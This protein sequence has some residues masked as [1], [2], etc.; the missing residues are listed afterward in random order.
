MT[1]PAAVRV[2]DLTL[3]PVAE[4]DTVDRSRLSP[5]VEKLYDDVVL[6]RRR[7]AA[8]HPFTAAV[9]RGEVSHEA[10]RHFVEGLYWHVSRTRPLFEGFFTKR[11]A[12]V[13]E[14]LAG[15]A[16]DGH[17][18][19]D[20]AA[21][22]LASLHALLRSFGSDPEALTA[23]IERFS[24]PQEWWWHETQLRA[25]VYSDDLP[26][27]VAAAALNAGTE[28]IVPWMCGPLADALEQGYGLSEQALL[29]LRFRITTDEVEHG[30]NGFLLLSH[31][32]DAADERLV[33]ECSLYLERLTLSMSAHLLGAG[34]RLAAQYPPAAS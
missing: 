22:M 12:E 1:A 26:W 2:S 19:E 5:W 24:P 32:V 17:N 21:T 28:G 10:L 23:G 31:Y 6:P 3:H 15:R 27:Q 16:E 25:A 9:A 8:A 20:V 30:D 33:G 4:V 7:A 13:E 18:P 14:F 11:P 34:S 29:W